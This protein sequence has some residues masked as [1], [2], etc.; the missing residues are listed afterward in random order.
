MLIIPRGFRK[1]SFS[2][3]ET[4]GCGQR[5]LDHSDGASESRGPTC[6]SPIGDQIT[7]FLEPMRE[8]NIAR[9]SASWRALQITSGVVAQTARLTAGA[10]TS[11]LS[12]RFRGRVALHLR[13]GLFVS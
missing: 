13:E 9:R 3:Q 4:G 10:T 2:N 1:L 6:N 12:T 5:Q 11:C 7:P 8:L